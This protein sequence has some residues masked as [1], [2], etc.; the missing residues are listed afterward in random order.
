MIIIH[1]EI[2]IVNTVIIRKKN[3]SIFDILKK[4]LYICNWYTIYQTQ[5]RI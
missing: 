2:Q 1:L 3:I 5:I 4:L